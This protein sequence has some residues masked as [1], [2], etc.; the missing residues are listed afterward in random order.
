MNSEQYL[1][2]ANK[3][4]WC[5]ND[6]NA[7]AARVQHAR[8]HLAHSTRTESVQSATLLNNENIESGSVASDKFPVKVTNVRHHCKTE[9]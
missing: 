6:R 7:R 5:N 9:Q 3:N 8:V 2:W 4:Y 1:N